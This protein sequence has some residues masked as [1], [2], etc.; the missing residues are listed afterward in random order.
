MMR[1]TVLVTVIAACLLVSAASAE[2]RTITRTELLDKVSGFWLGQLVGNY[3]GFPFENVYVEEAIPVLV[4]KYYT[5]FNADGLRI[6]RDDHRA[7]APYMFTAFDG[8]YSDDDT[9][10]EFVTLHAIEEHGL[11]INYEQIT[12]AWKTHINRRIWVSNRTARDLMDEGLIPP[13]TGTKENN[14]NWF[15]IDPQLVNEI[16]SAFYPGL[17]NKAAER[18]EWGARITNDSWGV[19]PTIV[20][21]VMISEAFFSDDPLHLV[22]TAMEHIP[23]EGP[24]HEGMADLLDWYEEDPDDWRATRQKLHDKYYHYDEDGYQA[25]VSVVSSLINGLCGVMAVLYGEGDFEKTVGIA[26]SAGYDCDNQAATAGGLIGVMHGASVIPEKFTHDCLPR[27]RWD[28]PFNDAYINYSR[29]ELPIHNTISGIV[30]RIA[31]IAEQAIVQ[32]G[33][34]KLEQDGEIVYRLP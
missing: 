25:P 20:Y 9:D 4:D 30:E 16:W 12:D 33:G 21:G 18:A 10:I 14:P 1:R 23:A 17:P 26:V 8:A 7:Y 34:A 19:H 24:F 32:E 5:P 2:E 31:N 3:L 22:E 15:Q 11:D 27:G 6:N 13:Q 28:K 29:D